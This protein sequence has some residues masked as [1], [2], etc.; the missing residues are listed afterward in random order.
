[1]GELIGSGVAGDIYK[2][3]LLESGRTIAIKRIGRISAENSE[4][5][6]LEKVRHRNIIQYYGSETTPEHHLLFLEYLPEQSLSHLM[7]SYGPL[8]E[9]TLKL[10][11]RQLLSALEY[12]HSRDIVHRDIKASNVLV[13]TDGQVRLSDFGCAGQLPSADVELR[14]SVLWTAPE[15]IKHGAYST[16]SDVWSLGC[17]VIEVLTG[18]GPWGGRHWDNEFSAIYE[19][20]V[21]D[22]TPQI[23]A[24]VSGPLQDLLGICLERDPTRRASCG[25]LLEH[26]YFN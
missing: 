9:P 22:I 26:S 25:R 5:G 2:G 10:Y 19:I 16:L 4:I 15:V 23:P 18:L 7:D 12:L 24:G 11:L 1:M 17:L 8:G 20:G 6:I 13:S 14:G 21:N 3:L